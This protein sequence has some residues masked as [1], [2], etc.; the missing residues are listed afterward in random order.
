MQVEVGHLEETIC[1]K[2]RF[3]I[4]QGKVQVQYGHIEDTIFLKLAIYMMVM[5]M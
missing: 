5:D 4:D 2:T 1:L 3:K